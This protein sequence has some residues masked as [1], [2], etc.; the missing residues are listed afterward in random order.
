MIW[1]KKDFHRSEDNVWIHFHTFDDSGV[2]DTEIR[3]RPT[4]S[5]GII[6]PA[7]M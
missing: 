1:K 2:R 7:N 3:D 6:K 5:R 4:E